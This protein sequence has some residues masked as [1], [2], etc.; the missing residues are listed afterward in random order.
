MIQQICLMAVTISFCG[1]LVA[2]A[3]ELCTYLNRSPKRTILLAPKASFS[4]EDWDK[5]ADKGYEVMSYNNNAPR[6]PKF[7]EMY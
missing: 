5:L 7:V 2:V 4:Q 3:S 1:S 6:E